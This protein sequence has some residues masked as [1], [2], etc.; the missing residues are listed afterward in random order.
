ML[1]TAAL[2]S[3]IAM[4]LTA[5]A[6]RARAQLA[7]LQADFVCTVTH[8]LK[9]PLAFI[10][11]LGE[12]LGRHQSQARIQEYAG[13]LSKEAWRLTR[14]IENV[15]TFARVSD[16]NAQHEFEELEVAELVEDA[17]NHFRPQLTGQGFELTLDVPAD[18]PLIRG[19][20]T[21]LVQALD[22]LLDNAIKYSGDRRAVAIRAVALDHSVQLEVSDRG[23]GIP[24]EEL[25]HVFDRFYR[26]RQTQAGGSGLGLAIVKRVVEDHAGQIEMRSVP[27]QGT[28]VRLVLPVRAA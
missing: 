8:E 1:A 27:A 12:T 2:A 21:R 20:R 6:V 26:G 13:L 23:T 3:V 28:S 14:L 17:L 16:P 19:D 25:E 11:L 7:T 5:R 22:N 4:L 18:I 24:P 9:T 10:R 15:L